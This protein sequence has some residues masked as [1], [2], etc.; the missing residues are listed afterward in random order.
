MTLKILT[1]AVALQSAEAWIVALTRLI[2][3]LFL[4]LERAR[5]R[6]LAGQFKLPLRAALEKKASPD[7]I[8]F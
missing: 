4:F 5:Q 3:P 7:P 2:F 8:A 1:F 6:D